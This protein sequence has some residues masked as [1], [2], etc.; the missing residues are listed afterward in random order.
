MITITPVKMSGVFADLANK[1]VEYKRDQGYKYHS[2]A[3]V[4]GRFCRFTEDYGLDEP[5]LTRELA[6]AWTAPREGEAAKSRLHRVC[7]PGRKFCV[8]RDRHQSRESEQIK[9]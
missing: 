6:M 2:E 7:W 3:K 8:K 4:L 1:F 9:G 5:V